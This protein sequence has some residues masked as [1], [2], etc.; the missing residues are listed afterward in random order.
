M[1]KDDDLDVECS[2]VSVKYYQAVCLIIVNV[3]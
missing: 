2:S 1:A 3:T